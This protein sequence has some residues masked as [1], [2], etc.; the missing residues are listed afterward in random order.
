MQE[1]LIRVDR[2]SF[3]SF[4]EANPAFRFLWHKKHWVGGASLAVGIAA[5]M[6]AS[7]LP[8]QYAGTTT[9]Q[10]GSIG[11]SDM[12]QQPIEQANVAASRFSSD[13]FKA[14]IVKESG[15][16]LGE[17]DAKQAMASL[18]AGARPST[19]T[20]DVQVVATSPE[21]VVQILDAA[22][23][24]LAKH[25]EVSS[26]P[27]LQ[28]LRDQLRSV[29]DDME[30]LEKPAQ[31]SPT[32]SLVYVTAATHLFSLYERSRLKA[33]ERHFRDRLK[34]FEPTRAIAVPS[35]QLRPA[36]P[37][38]LRYAAV[39]SLA[40]LILLTTLVLLIAP[41]NSSRPGR[42]RSDELMA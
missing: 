41:S 23:S 14:S 33:L 42:G 30:E 20:I 34:L 27:R 1:A 37:R 5:Y 13:S 22:A 11:S 10:V 26:A 19:A 4:L 7:L 3:G 31:A 17:R 8:A 6:L 9:V 39:S 36:G 21:S 32:D 24:A 35:V 16:P 38:R 28:V 12:V 2:S 29:Q 25:H 15:L 18:S 40:A